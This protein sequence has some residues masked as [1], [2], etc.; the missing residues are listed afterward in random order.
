MFRGAAPGSLCFG[1]FLVVLLVSVGFGGFRVNSVEL[2]ADRNTERPT[3]TRDRRPPIPL[4]SERIVPL[5][6]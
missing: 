1:G 6:P 2:S 5:A 3:W 4:R